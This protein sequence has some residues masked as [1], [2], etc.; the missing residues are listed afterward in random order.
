MRGFMHLITIL[1]L[2]IAVNANPR[3]YKEEKDRVEDL[4]IGKEE[5]TEY[6]SKR[7]PSERSDNALLEEAEVDKDQHASERLV[8]TKGIAQVSGNRLT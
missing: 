1:A 7:G 8:R 3:G 6:E 5:I 2:W 4:T